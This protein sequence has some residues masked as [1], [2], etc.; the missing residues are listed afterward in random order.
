MIE[1]P[2]IGNI[3]Y[4]IGTWRDLKAIY[5]ITIDAIV[6][7]KIVDCSYEVEYNT[8]YQIINAGGD[9]F[10]SNHT[11]V[12]RVDDANKAI[13]RIEDYF[14]DHNGTCISNQNEN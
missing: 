7:N 11:D 4:V 9:A 5:A 2:K 14:K 6:D 1:N 13:A 3:A 8:N 10:I 12:E